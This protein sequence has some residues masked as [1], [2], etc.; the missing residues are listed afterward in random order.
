[1]NSNRKAKLMPLRATLAAALAIIIATA[2][3]PSAH[4][5]GG[6]GGVG[7]V[8]GVGGMGGMGGMGGIGAIGA[9]GVHGNPAGGFVGVN[10]GQLGGIGVMAVPNLAVQEMRELKLAGQV[11]ANP[12]RLPSGAR[13]VQLRVNG[14]MVPMALDSELGSSDLEFNP[15]NRKAE[16]LYHAL[17]TKQVAVIGDEKLRNQIV[18]A[19][20]ENGTQ[21]LEIQGYV[22]NQT[23]PYF[24]V[25]SVEAAK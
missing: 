8:G 16:D 14:Q 19:A 9:A 11:P 25:K 15:G 2:Y 6:A 13:I 20:S 10:G 17:L 23:T 4:A 22:F 3:A 18:Q 24:V 21:A 5:F 12:D 1:M 7:G